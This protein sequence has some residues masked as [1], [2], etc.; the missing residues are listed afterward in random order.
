MIKCEIERNSILYSI[1]LV[2]D[3]SFIMFPRR[4]SEDIVIYNTPLRGSAQLF[5]SSLVVMRL[6]STYSGYGGQ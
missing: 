4:R 6:A 2:D 3:I 5:I 1:S